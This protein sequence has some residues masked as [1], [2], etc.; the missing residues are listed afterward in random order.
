MEDRKE[1][2]NSAQPVRIN[3]SVR[4]LAVDTAPKQVDFAK[5]YHYVIEDLR[6]IAFI[7]LGLLILLIALALIIG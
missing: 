2:S 4:P 6:R 3:R 5:E 7:A 1:A